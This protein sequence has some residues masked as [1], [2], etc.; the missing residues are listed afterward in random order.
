[1]EPRTRAGTNMERGDRRLIL[2]VELIDVGRGKIS[3]GT[4]GPWTTYGDLEE[5]R[6]TVAPFLLEALGRRSG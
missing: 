5:V 3:Y 6:Y 4:G 1:M 2:A